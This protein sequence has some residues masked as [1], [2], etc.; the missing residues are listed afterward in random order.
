MEYGRIVRDAWQITWRHPFL[1]V[2]GLF[3]GGAASTSFNFRGSGNSSA[4][5]EQ[6]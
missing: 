6:S 5:G 3:A 4:A 2:L 1:W